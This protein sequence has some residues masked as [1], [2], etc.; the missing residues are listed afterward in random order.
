[1]EKPSIGGWIGNV[2]EV[3][4]IIVIWAGLYFMVL[5]LAAF[6]NKL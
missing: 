6:F 3:I 5:G 4:A 1:M 2:F